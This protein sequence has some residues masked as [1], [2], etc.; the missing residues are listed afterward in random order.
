MTQ[1]L[2]FLKRSKTLN[3]PGKALLFTKH[4]SFFIA[5]MKWKKIV[6]TLILIFFTNKWAVLQDLNGSHPVELHSVV[7]KHLTTMIYLVA[8][9]IKVEYAYLLEVH[10]EVLGVRN[11][12]VR[13]LTYGTTQQNEWKSFSSL[14]VYKQNIKTHITHCRRCSLTLQRTFNI[15][16]KISKNTH[17]TKITKQIHFICILHSLFFVSIVY[18]HTSY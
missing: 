8:M 14:T 15:Y 11:E 18:N 16:T 4:I 1:L 13:Q 7:P 6:T 9:F 2:K 3:S 12:F 10:E 17:F 5:F